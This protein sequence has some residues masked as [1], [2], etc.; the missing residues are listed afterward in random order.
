MIFFFFLGIFG[1]VFRTKRV[2]NLNIFGSGELGGGQ[3]SVLLLPNDL[4]SVHS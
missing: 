4:G 3:V 1:K 2:S